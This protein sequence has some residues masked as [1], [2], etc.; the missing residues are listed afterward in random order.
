M[1]PF[2]ALRLVLAAA[3]LAIAPSF[4]TPAAAAPSIVRIGITQQPNTLNPLIGTQAFENYI[5]EGVFSALTLFDDKGALQPDLATA[6]PT[7]ANGG[8]SADGRTITFHLRAG[9]K[10]QDGVPLTSDDV[11]FTFA[12]MH[13]PSV[14]YSQLSEYEDIERLDAPDPLT[15]VLHLKKPSADILRLVFV[16]GQ[17]GSIVPKHVLEHVADMRSAAFNAKPIGSGAFIVDRWERG[18]QVVLRANPG[19]FRG[20]PAIDEIHIRFLPDGNSLA[21]ALRTG[22][23]DLCPTLPSGA[24]PMVA[25]LPGMRVFNVTG[26]SGVL[27]WFQT[28]AAPFEDARVR[29][30]FTLAVDRAQLLHDA[31]HDKGI[32]ADDILWPALPEYNPRSF[33]VAPQPAEARRLLERAGWRTGADGVRSKNGERLAVTLSV[34]A[35]SP[36]L[37]AAA[38]NVQSMWKAIGAEVDVAARPTNT[39]NDPQGPMARGA[40]QLL[41]SSYGFSDTADRSE[42]ITT[43]AIPPHGFNW[44]RYANARVDQLVSDGQTTL[45]ESRRKAIYGAISRQLAEDDALVPLLWVSIN[46]V[47]SDRIANFK[48][49]PVNSDLWNAYEWRLK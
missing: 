20:R 14:P 40:F 12:K 44:M 28:Q 21:I 15:V 11:R 10:W 42:L 39:I 45:D 3:L 35:E 9:V 48:A 19:Y 47:V 23:I 5:M 4:S 2:M 43:R 8:I 31:L 32:V 25:G 22:E 30:A 37:R 26:T 38:V 17:F 29:R 6:V 18:S 24:L 36:A 49:E 33:E 34:G 46:Y 1:V 27:L 16:S 7:R 13:D 41:L